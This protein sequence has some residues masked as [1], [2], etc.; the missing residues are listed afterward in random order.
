MRNQPQTGDSAKLLNQLESADKG[1][2]AAVK[3]DAMGYAFRSRQAP[4]TQ[5]PM[6]LDS[7]T[8]FAA[9]SL[10][11]NVAAER[12]G[13]GSISRLPPTRPKP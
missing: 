5:E 4:G 12:Q 9:R 6:K 1:I 11:A 7:P 2:T 10:Q 13:K 3:D 8:W